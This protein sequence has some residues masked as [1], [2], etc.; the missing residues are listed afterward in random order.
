MAAPNPRLPR[1]GGALLAGAILIG[2]LVGAV[3]GEPSIGFL[4]GLGVGLALMVLVWLIDR[5]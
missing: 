2:V 4:A 1:A 5:R 3:V